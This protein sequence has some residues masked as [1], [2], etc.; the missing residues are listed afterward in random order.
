MTRLSKIFKWY[1]R[2]RWTICFRCFPL[3]RNMPQS[4][5]GFNL[6]SKWRPNSEINNLLCPLD[7][8]GTRVRDQSNAN[9]TKAAGSTSEPK[10][11]QRLRHPRTGTRLREQTNDTHL[12]TGPPLRAS[13]R[14]YLYIQ[15]QRN[16][17][18]SLG[19]HWILLATLC[20]LLTPFGFL[21]ESLIHSA[22]RKF[23]GRAKSPV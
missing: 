10:Q 17:F 20:A 4:F 9:V 2:P 18:Y 7:C 5:M 13:Q 8:T 14:Q 12:G 19:Q 15:A 11:R 3:F 23:E 21:F 1:A 6:I 22:T 16:K